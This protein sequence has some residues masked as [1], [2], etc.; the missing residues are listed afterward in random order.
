MRQETGRR[1][2]DLRTNE[3]RIAQ[4]NF[5]Y[6]LGIDIIYLV[7]VEYC[8]QNITDDTLNFVCIKSS[9]SIFKFFL[10]FKEVGVQNV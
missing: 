9:V 4:E 1:I 10:S 7:R 3:L 2:K 6:V 5:T 8:E